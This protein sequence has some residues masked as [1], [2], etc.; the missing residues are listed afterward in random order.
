LAENFFGAWALTSFTA[1][2]S[3]RYDFHVNVQE[4]VNN[5]V[6]D[7]RNSSIFLG[8]DLFAPLPL[9]FEF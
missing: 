7:A 6:P 8:F 3:Q 2:I 5:K 4:P 9:P 1:E